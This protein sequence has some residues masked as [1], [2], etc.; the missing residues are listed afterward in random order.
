M[1]LY[2]S[3]TCAIS[4]FFAF[5]NERRALYSDFN[6]PNKGKQIMRNNSLSFT[7]TCLYFSTNA[8]FQFLLQRWLITVREK[9]A[10]MTVENGFFSCFTNNSCIA[11][12]Y[13]GYIFPSGNTK[14]SFSCQNGNWVPVLSSCKSKLVVWNQFKLFITSTSLNNIK[15]CFGMQLLISRQNI[16]KSTCWYMYI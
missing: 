16:I 7:C 6:Y 3:F 14:D 13:H 4:F 5:E 15:V 9:M 2:F 1:S 10:N 8:L 11:E 12:C